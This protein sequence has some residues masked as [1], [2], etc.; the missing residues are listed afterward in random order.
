MTPAEPPLD[1]LLDHLKRQRGFDF[2]GYKRS[3]LERRIRKRMALVGCDDY[4][5]YLDYLEVHPDE[6]AELFNT[7]LIN[8]TS[9][10]RDTTAWDHL[11]EEV[12]PAVL[13]ARA[14]DDDAIR[15]W[16]AGCASGQ[17]AYSLAMMLA[18]A[19]GEPEFHGRVK[20]YAT[21]VDEEALALARAA[22]YTAK[23]VEDVPPE[24]LER[25]FERVDA[26]YGFRKDLRR[27]VIFGRN[28]LVQDAPISRIDILACRNTL[29][30]FTA[31]T[32]ARIVGRLH[33]ALRDEGVLFLGKSETLIAHSERFRP[34]DIKH[35]I[36]RK[37]HAPRRR[38][39]PAF[40]LLGEPA[41]DGEALPTLRDS[42]LDATP[43]AQVV[44]T[45]AGALGFAN[46]RAQV[47]FQLGA[48]DLG[49]PLQDLELSYRPLELRSVL[50]KAYA[51]RR[52]TLERAVRHTDADGVARVLD[53]QVT[54]LYTENA[55]LGASI[56]YNDVTT[57]HA[58]QQELDRSRTELEN[59][60]EELQSTVEELETTNEELQSTNEELE[61]TNEELQSTNE[62]L[63]TTNEEL[64][65]T[66]EELE[67]INIELHQ[68]TL[69]LND[70]NVFLETIL[71]SMGLGVAVL[72]R[73]Q[74]IRV[75]NAHAEDLWGVRADE[76]RGH[77]ILSLDIGLP[78]DQLRTGLRA[79]LSGG[80]VE[81]LLSATNR[82]G[83]RIRCRV[84]VLPL[85]VD[86]DEPG[87]S[88][89][90]MED[91]PISGDGDGDG[92]SDGDGD[93]PAAPRETERGA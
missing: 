59:A 47:L 25:Y 91:S 18:E 88:I 8:V 72:D 67:T 53:V 42:A 76:V 77:H 74:R 1:A 69:E 27:S 51:E 5:A 78:L 87:G 30:Y 66:N 3:T 55:L 4:G 15:V 23:E 85:E 9:F 26:R 73:D 37:V 17:E 48:P 83:Q 75:W 82:R 49:R 20:I 6:F 13:A 52:P 2:T 43:V 44:L 92:R 84:V 40:P 35:R 31:E 41:Y 86:G 33:F 64:H 24:L 57:A 60:Y 62:E 93:R 79:A 89:L 50:E 7:I 28:D 16:S 54:P 68:R 21:D 32:Q 65:S 46:Q 11:R 12:L 58:L 19:L 36:F 71:T 34:T 81:E 90:L 29:M 63:E 70:A 61:T 38:E 14:D 39:R 45:E 10:F 56:T 22:V 80:R